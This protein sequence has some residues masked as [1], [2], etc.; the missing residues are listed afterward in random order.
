MMT[1]FFYPSIVYLRVLG[2]ILQNI[3]AGYLGLILITPLPGIDPINIVKKLI[4]AVVFYFLAVKL[5]EVTS[6]I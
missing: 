2:G 4:M 5:E 6:R 3:S 1:R